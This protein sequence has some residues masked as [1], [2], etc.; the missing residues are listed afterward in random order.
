MVAIRVLNLR[1]LKDTGFIDLKPITLLLG[2]NS[3]GKSTFLRLFPL[4][5]QSMETRI[6]GAL[7]LNGD[8]VDFGTYADAIHKNGADTKIGI[9]IRD[10]T[11]K[12]GEFTYGVT[13]GSKDNVVTTL[14]RK[15]TQFQD[16]DYTY[17]FEES[18]T[19][20]LKEDLP[21]G[22][23][24]NAM[25]TSGSR[26][27][28][29]IMPQ[30]LI[31]LMAGM[32]WL[33]ALAQCRYATPLR[34]TAKRYYLRQ[35]LTVDEIHARGENLAMVLTSFQE[36]KMAAFHAWTLKHFGFRVFCETSAGHA[37]IF[38]QEGDGPKHN[39]ADTGFGFSQVLP[40][41]TQLWMLTET[42]KDAQHGYPIVYA[43]EQPEL[44]LHPRLHALLADAFVVTNQ[45]AKAKGQEI[46]LLIET[47]SETIAN[48]L[49]Q[50]IRHGSCDKD[51]MGVYLFEKERGSKTATV[52]HIEYNQ[53]GYLVGWPAGFFEPELFF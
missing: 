21:K 52:R 35:G 11:D 2:G 18:H 3:S 23:V 12:L 27:S 16:K 9:E 46:I 37:S 6:Q 53:K 28:V 45:T 39:L 47:H 19:A 40:I 1:C 24:S 29:E 31:P 25:F 20:K 22:V 10:K 5:R 48:R 43:I 4:L 50:R 41:I 38:L 26:E 13:I 33:G 8:L 14:E 32:S 51:D 34:D 30:E 49:G 42:T 44:H 36:Q 15:Y 7:H 17:L